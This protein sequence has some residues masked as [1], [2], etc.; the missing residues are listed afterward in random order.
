MLL[1]ALQV[2]ETFI[3]SSECNYTNAAQIANI[4]NI[5][6]L[7]AATLMAELPC[8]ASSDNTTAS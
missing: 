3:K 1:D 7:P 4:N 5:V 6:M 2:P 8:G